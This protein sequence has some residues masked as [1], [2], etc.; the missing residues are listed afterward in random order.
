MIY[1]C[2]C[3]LNYSQIVCLVEVAPGKAN[4]ILYMHKCIC[5]HLSFVINNMSCISVSDRHKVS[6][7]R[8]KWLV[9]K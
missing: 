9:A 1:A 2:E 6:E 8:W 7:R 5:L 4:F 3:H